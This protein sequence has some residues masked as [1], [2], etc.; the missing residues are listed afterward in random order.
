M[1]IGATK[2]RTCAP[3]VCDLREHRDL[4]AGIEGPGSE[5]RL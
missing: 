3:G 1:E 2:P 5:R 4:K